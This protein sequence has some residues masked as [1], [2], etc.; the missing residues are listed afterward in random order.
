MKF[1]KRLFGKKIKRQEPI[2]YVEEDTRCDLCELKDQCNLTE[3]TMLADTKKHYANVMGDKC[4]KETGVDISLKAIQEYADEKGIKKKIE[5]M[6]FSEKDSLRFKV[7]FR[8]CAGKE[9]EE[10][11]NKERKEFAKG[12]AEAFKKSIFG[13]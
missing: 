4:K 8:H 13:D 9:I 10:L 12:F 7:I 1:L 5:D 2:P 6:T 3:V 11:T